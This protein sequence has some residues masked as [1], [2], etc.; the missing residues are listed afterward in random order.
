MRSHATVCTALALATTL[1]T[2][3]QWDPNNGQWGKADPTDLRVMTWNVEDNIRTDESK[4]ETANAWTAIA[5]T[6]AAM[7][8]DILILQECGDNGFVGGVDSVGDLT[9][10]CELLIHGGADPFLG[11]T[12]GA[13]VQKYDA[14]F[15]LP[16]I[17]VSADTD[18]FNRNVILSRYPF[19]DLNGDAQAQFHDINILADA[20]APGGDGGIRGFMVAEI[21]L[22]DAIWAGDVVVGNSHL[23]AG[24]SGSDLDDREEAAQ[25]IAYF[26]DYQY[27]GAGTGTPDPNF[28]VRIG[29]PSVILNNVTPF[30]WGGDWNEDEATNGRKGP[31]EWM[32]LAEFAGGTDGTDRDTTDAVYDNASDPFTG[33]TDTRGSAKLDYLAWPD[34]VT[35][36]RNEWIFNTASMS[37]Q[38]VPPEF[39]I[40]GWTLYSGRASDHLAVLVDL[41]MAPAS[42]PCPSDLDG[43][44]TV[45]GADLGLLLGAWATPG[46]GDLDGSGSVGGGDI[47]IL[48][49]D[50]GPCP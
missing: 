12:V 47:G 40:S 4:I 5:R 9:T 35:T 31:A 46:P 8:P 13:Y 18:S 43:S 19:S 24:G 49:G 1:A 6:I 28:K 26:I 42:P 20:Y 17:F 15:D 7:K 21:D 25:N 50:W 29:N 44:G 34:S 37:A 33:D 38:Q 39:Q 22:D 30:V 10:V 45:D 27:N 48:L 2:H 36:S 14:S 11:G 3:A 41:V 23:K 32:T 16:Y